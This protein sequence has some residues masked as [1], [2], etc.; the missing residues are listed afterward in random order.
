MSDFLENWDDEAWDSIV[1]DFVDALILNNSD[2][3]DSVFSDPG[4]SSDVKLILKDLKAS[5]IVQD[6]IEEWEAEERGVFDDL[7]FEIPG[8]L[9]RGHYW[10]EHHV[11]PAIRLL[12]KYIK[13]LAAADVDFL[14]LIQFLIFAI[15]QVAIVSNAFKRYAL[16]LHTGPPG[17]KQLFKTQ[18]ALRR[19][20]VSDIL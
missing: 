2:F 6:A 13:R 18:V 9:E 20:L 16:N 3:I 17:K 10:R 12:G 4:I 1:S 19:V 11:V 14:H 15:K 8:F 5:W 7:R